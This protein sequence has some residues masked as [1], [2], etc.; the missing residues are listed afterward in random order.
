MS[1]P[2]ADPAREVSV[3]VAAG[4]PARL[5]LSNPNGE[6]VSVDV[7]A[8]GV[9]GPVDL[10]RSGT[11]IPALGTVTL[12]IGEIPPAALTITADDRVTAAVEV[13]RGVDGGTD[14]AVFPAVDKLN[15]RQL[16]MLPED[17][18]ASML[19]GPGEGTLGLVGLRLSLIHI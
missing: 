3:P 17:I 12:D 7:S 15:S 10:A 11:S 16:L 1:G 13:T 8:A 14:F 5:R 19:F 18:D 4:G 2:V 9:D 6:P